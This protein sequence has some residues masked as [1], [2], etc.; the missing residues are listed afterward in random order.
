MEYINGAMTEKL[1]Q[2]RVIAVA[3]LWWKH[4]IFHRNIISNN[5]KIHSYFKT[6]NML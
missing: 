5:S 6:L 4:E 1:F 3:F 2:G